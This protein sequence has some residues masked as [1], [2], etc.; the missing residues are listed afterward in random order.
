VE[1]EDKST[2]GKY[3]RINLADQP[4]KGLSHEE[5]HDLISTHGEQAKNKYENLLSELKTKLLSLHPEVTLSIFSFYGLSS[6]SPKKEELDRVKVLHSE[7]EFLQAFFLTHEL[8]SFN[9]DRDVSKLIIRFFELRTLVSELSSAFHSKHLEP[10]KN[11]DDVARRQFTVQSEMRSH[12]TFTRGL[13]P[14]R[15]LQFLPELF[16][17]LDQI[18]EKELGITVKYIV[19]MYFNLMDLLKERLNKHQEQ[20]QEIVKSNEINEIIDVYVRAFYD[21]DSENEEELKTFI[22]ENNFNVK[23]LKEF[24]LLESNLFL[25]DIYLLTPEAFQSSYPIPISVEN[26]IRIVDK[27]SLTYGDLE[28]YE[29]EHFFMDNPIWKRPF[30][31]YDDTTYFCFIP[32]LL[33]SFCLEQIEF[34]LEDYENVWS[35]YTKTRTDY[36]EAKTKELFRAA[37]PEAKVFTGS[38]WNDPVDQKEYENDLLVLIDTTAFVIEAKSG[39]VRP[40]AKRGDRGSLE[41]DIKKLFVESAHQANRFISFLKDHPK[42]VF[43]TK[44]GKPNKVDASQIEFF[45]PLTITLENLGDISAHI[46]SL[47]NSG[48]I[49]KEVE[50]IPSVSIFD[51]ETIFDILSTTALKLHYFKWRAKLEGQTYYT[52]SSIDLLGVYVEEGFIETLNANENDLLLLENQ[53]EIFDLYLLRDYFKQLSA[54]PSR[55]FTEWWQR[56]LQKAETTKYL[57][58]TELTA[59]LLNAS[60]QDQIEIE[61]LFQNA[62]F[63]LRHNNDKQTMQVVFTTIDAVI[64]FVAYKDIPHELLDQFIDAITYKNQK[65]V[66]KKQM[67]IIG[68]DVNRANEDFPYSFIEAMKN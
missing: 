58:W 46:R 27:L 34:L 21:G 14:H 17:K 55:K 50:T 43:K 6:Y 36:L 68:L 41:G 66:D 51:L 54:K 8:T 60:Y 7:I 20:I 3:V 30:I 42:Y 35:R 67:V 47:K 62:I 45:L 4:F 61:S 57:G 1:H 16:A 25:P 15:T 11:L 29:V 22:S 65:R 18:I 10:Y 26:V 24:V 19:L 40:K 59:I 5:I 56:I 37:F 23:D 39:K 31:K 52:G 28:D 38:K 64:Y 2:E 12:T 63:S 9:P 49:D 44:K 33:L 53:S 13:Y 32:G 48:Y